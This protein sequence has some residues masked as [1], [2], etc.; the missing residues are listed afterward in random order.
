MDGDLAL[1]QNKTLKSKVTTQTK[2]ADKSENQVIRDF[3]NVTSISKK[4]NKIK[5]L[6]TAEA[7]LFYT[8]FYRKCTLSGTLLEKGWKFSQGS[9]LGCIS[10]GVYKNPKKSGTS[11]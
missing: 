1:F 5:L 4:S 10:N 7:K 6:N 11:K 3:R 8:Y 9:C 2:N